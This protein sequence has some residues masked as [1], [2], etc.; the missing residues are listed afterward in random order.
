MN[1]FTGLALRGS[2][3]ASRPPC[4]TARGSWARRRCRPPSLA[5]SSSQLCLQIPRETRER[6]STC[7]ILGDREGEH[8]RR[9]ISTYLLPADDSAGLALDDH[10]LGG[11]EEEAGRGKE[12][13]LVEVLHDVG[14]LLCLELDVYAQNETA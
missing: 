7:I 11:A 10:V 6:R 3:R 2:R 9:R 13:G 4:C 5:L 14:H 8:R 12:P 1:P